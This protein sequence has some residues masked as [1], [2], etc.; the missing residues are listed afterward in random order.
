[1]YNVEKYL[2][3]CMESLVHQTMKDI[4]I[5]VVNDGSPDN[6]LQ[7]LK[8]YEK[9][10]GEFVKVYTTENR[11]VSHARN[12]GLDRA[13][14]EYV[15]FVDSDDY[16]ELNMCE[17]LYN[18]ATKDGNDLVVCGRYNV[19]ENPDGSIRR[20]EQ[21]TNQISQNFRLEDKKFEFARL[22]PFPWDKI[23]K[24]TLLE[25]IRFPEDIRFE[26]L[27]LSYKV[28]CNAKSIGVL[29]EPLYNY[30]RTTQGGFLNSF[31]EGTLDIIKAFDV[32]FAYMEEHKY[33]EVFREE[34]SYIC[35]RHFLFRYAAFFTDDN[36]G[37]FELKKRIINETQDFLD[38]KVPDWKTNHYLI[39]ASAP[40]LT[41]KL[42]LYTNRRKLI[43]QVHLRDLMPLFLLKILRKAKNLVVKV[44]KKARKFK[45]SR[46]KKALLKKKLPFLNLFFKPDADKYTKL[47]ESMS[48]RPDVIFLES[49]HGADVAGNIFAIIRELTKE[50]YKGFKVYLALEEGLFDTYTKMFTKYQIQNVTFVPMKSTQYLEMLASAKFL[51]TD[52]S[53]PT[54]YIKKEDQVYL[55]TWHG[56]PLKAMGRI[57]PER[58]Y[59]LGNV[60]RNFLIADYL[61]Y[62]NEFSKD[63]FLKDYMIDQVYKGTVLLSG[64]PR[65]CAFFATHRYEEI[66]S[67]C[68]LTDMQVMVYMPTWRGLLH[69]MESKKQ[70]K[71][72]YN[73]FVKIDRKLTDQQVM[74]VKLHPFVKTAIDYS[75]F[76]HIK[77]F[78][79]EYEPYD[80]LNA[81][82]L[83]ITDYSSIMFDYAVSKK[84]IIL[85]TYDR[86]EY[87]T[88]RGMYLD[89]NKVELPKADT[90]EELIAEINKE[91]HAYPEFFAEYC[92]LDNKDCTKNVCETV[93]LNRNVEG[94]QK[95]TCNYD[96]KKNVMYYVNRVPKGDDVY[97]LM[98]SF[99]SFDTTKFNYFISFQA[100]SL[101]KESRAL[102]LLP[103]EMGYFPLQAGTNATGSEKFA[104][105]LM[106]HFGINNSFT[107]RKLTDLAAREQKKHYGTIQFEHVYGNMDANDWMKVRRMK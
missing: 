19:Y 7:I 95:E 52:T 50:E 49:K 46:N 101:K 105:F 78:P 77:P 65:N 26:D 29:E 55:N 5:I 89:L 42:G 30:R 107:N 51:V 13:T 32:L 75:D 88:G 61:L 20:K 44:G 85:F 97:E 6:S 64:Y 23:F 25:G 8:K 74:F 104:L 33:M 36:R 24:R 28:V 31:S 83:L 99:Q 34:L 53:F 4:E 16:I 12:Y 84:K 18:K 67:E 39:Y 38:E 70:I 69:K 27:V 62:Q 80:F 82:D 63:I 98:K 103:T 71:E 60:Q 93:F 81:S 22:S 106:D 58:E 21:K 92:S 47:Y 56:T 9:K 76:V 45:R 43:R 37:K 54:Y 40:S 100:E 96:A 17:K 15:M 90:V 1:M 73:Y 35:A 68:G 3:T 72:I 94:L 86:D 102:S 41:K 2:R 48:V 14:G 91:E 57:V 79:E 10:Y 11:G 66:R 59:G 87:L